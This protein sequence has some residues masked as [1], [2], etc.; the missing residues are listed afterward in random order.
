MIIN[1]HKIPWG[2]NSPYVT[3]F[4]FSS[5]FTLLHFPIM[6]SMINSTSYVLMWLLIFSV[7]LPTPEDG[8][9]LFDFSKNLIDNTTCCLLV[10][11]AKSRGVEQARDAMFSGMITIR[12]RIMSFFDV[13]FLFI[14]VK[15]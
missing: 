15:R 12:L 10:D 14:Q 3:F 11:L 1:N 7:K 2:E 13:K 6:I 8:E 4:Y 5:F 9:M